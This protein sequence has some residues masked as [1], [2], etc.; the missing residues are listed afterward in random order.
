V[1]VQRQRFSVRFH[2][3]GSHAFSSEIIGTE[4]IIG[5]KLSGTWLC[6]PFCCWK[7]ISQTTWTH[8]PWTKRAACMKT[9]HCLQENSDSHLASQVTNAGKSISP[10]LILLLIFSQRKLLRFPDK[11]LT[12]LAGSFGYVSPEVIK[13]TG[14]VDIW[15]TGITTLRMH[16]RTTSS[17]LSLHSHHHLC[18]PLRQTPSFRDNTTALA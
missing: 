17:F 2:D 15:W 5:T 6:I 16:R 10:P 4:S 13:I 1:I 11:Q 3:L 14:H 8:N 18:S 12:S 9:L 7:C